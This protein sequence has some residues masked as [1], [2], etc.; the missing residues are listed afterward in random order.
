MG[1]VQA[2]NITVCNDGCDYSS[3]T[4]SVNDAKPGDT[5]EVLGGTYRENINVTKPLILQGL[6]NANGMPVVEAGQNGSAIILSADGIIVKGFEVRKAVG[7]LIRGWAGITVKSNNNTISGNIAIDNDNGIYIQSKNNIVIGN[8]LTRNQYGIMLKSSQNNIIN[9]NNISNNIH[10][11]DLVSAIRNKLTGNSVLDNDYGILLDSSTQNILKD[12]IMSGN[13][14]NFGAEGLNFIDKSNFVDGKPIFY[15]SGI[16]GLFISSKSEVGTFYCDNCKNVTIKDLTLKNNTNGIILKNTTDSIIENNTL[17]SNSFGIYLSNS[18]RNILRNNTLHNN[19]IDGLKL[20]SSAENIIKNNAIIEN[21][22]CGMSLLFSDGNNFTANNISC[23]NN[24]LSLNS[25][26]ENRILKNIFKFN[27]V[28]AILA[29]RS[30]QN[31]IAWNSFGENN[32][33]ISLISSDIN[34]FIYNNITGN[35]IG[36]K[37]Q[38][39]SNN[40]VLINKFSYNKKGIAFNPSYQNI[41]S[42][43][44]ML[45]NERE[46]VE[47]APCPTQCPPGG[48]KPTSDMIDNA[49]DNSIMPDNNENILSYILGLLNV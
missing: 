17:C 44:T 8:N 25:S 20:D 15:L 47:F 23:N 10:G 37:L 14:N 38:F 1:I 11:I 49:P 27:K 42:D 39:S 13:T 24:G 5:I 18:S 33:G 28:H 48:C 32:I 21:D 40:S 26:E 3:I 46:F 35:L 36:L 22:Q 7:H 2:A 43:N 12:N 45:K 16:S 6:S 19:R 4:T 29:F 41:I 31:I 34:Y 9:D 30:G